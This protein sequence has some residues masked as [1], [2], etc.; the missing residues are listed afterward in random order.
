MP[1]TNPTLGQQQFF[2]CYIRASEYE[3][4]VRF[5]ISSIS[6]ECDKRNFQAVIHIGT[7]LLKDVPKAQDASEE[8]V[9]N[10]FAEFMDAGA[11]FSCLL[12]SGRRIQNFIRICLKAYIIIRKPIKYCSNTVFRN[13]VH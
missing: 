5:G 12:C 9:P 8:L 6:S 11:K 13:Y 10:P 7:E 4:A 1:G 2:D 3:E